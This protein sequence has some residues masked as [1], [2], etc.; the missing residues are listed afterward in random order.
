MFVREAATVI[1]YS[2]GTTAINES[3][4]PRLFRAAEHVNAYQDAARK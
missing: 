1:R 2:L 3:E 4:G